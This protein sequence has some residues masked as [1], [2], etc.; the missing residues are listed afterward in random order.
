MWSFTQRRRSFTQRR[1]SFSPRRR[2]FSRRTAKV[3]KTL[4]WTFGT[5]N[6]DW[7]L[8]TRPAGHGPSS[9]PPPNECSLNALHTWTSLLGSLSLKQYLSHSLFIKLS[10]SQTLFNALSTLM[11][12]LI[13]NLK[14][15][16]SAQVSKVSGKN[17]VT[18][19]VSDW[20]GLLI[21]SRWSQTS[22]YNAHIL[23]D[24]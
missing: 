15:S 22:S 21:I 2:S 3:Q 23:P 7:D 14:L 16:L 6:L 9:S 13:I 19:P 24:T 5:Y 1:R 8:S 12:S 4:C 18:T 17:L 11:L 20:P 10:L